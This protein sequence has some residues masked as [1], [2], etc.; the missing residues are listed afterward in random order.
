MEQVA[1]H[2]PAGPIGALLRQL[3]GGQTLAGQH[4]EGREHGAAQERL[5]QLRLVHEGEVLGGVEEGEGGEGGGG[6][7]EEGG[8][9]TVMGAALLL[10]L[11]YYTFTTHLPLLNDTYTS[12]SF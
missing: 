12:F 8:R 6:E 1:A 5:P 3:D 9:T 7:G 4:L 2:G 11:F 10:K